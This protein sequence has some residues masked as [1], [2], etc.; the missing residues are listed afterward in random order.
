MVFFV[1]RDP[2]ASVRLASGGRGAARRPS[3]KMHDL[4][5]W[6]KQDPPTTGAQC[7]A[8]VHVLRVH[9]VPLVE[10]A[11]RLRVG[12]PHEEARAAD[13]IRILPAARELFD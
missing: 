13:P 6:R 8:E 5:V 3:S 4:D 10:A 11:D 1:K 9:E 2:A 7:R 12:A